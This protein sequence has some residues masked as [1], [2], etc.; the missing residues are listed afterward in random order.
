MDI[1]EICHSRD[2]VIHHIGA[3][4]DN[5]RIILSLSDDPA[6]FYVI[7]LDSVRSYFHSPGDAAPVVINTGEVGSFG[8]WL[9]KGGKYCQVEVSPKSGTGCKVIAIAKRVQ[10]RTCSEDG[11]DQN[12]PG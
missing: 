11:L 7:D 4:D 1:E 3:R 6:P 5:L 12:F 10:Y 9:E 2:V 8:W